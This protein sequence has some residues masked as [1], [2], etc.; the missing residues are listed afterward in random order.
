MSQDGMMS[1]EEERSTKAQETELTPEAD[2]EQAPSV[3]PVVAGAML[4]GPMAKAQRQALV[5]SVGQN[6]GNRQVQ[7][8][9]GT[10]RRKSAS[11]GPEG[12]PL[13]S[14]IA[15]RIQSARAT[16]QP[17]PGHIAEQMS[18][19]LGQDVSR[20]QVVTSPEINHDL[21]AKAATIGR[22][23]IVNSSSDLE[24]K[25]LMRHE[26]THAIQQGFSDAPPTSIGAADTEHEKAAEHAAVSGGSAQGV[27][28]EVE[29]GTLGLMREDSLV[30]RAG[31]EEEEEGQEVG[32][33]RDP[34]A[35][36]RAGEEDEE[37]GQEVGLMRDP[38][39]LQR[40]GEEDEEEGQEV[41]LM[42]E[43]NAVQRHPGEEE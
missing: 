40:A 34:N 12:G 1:Y 6:F 27:Q 26:L 23:V 14:D 28:R 19:D 11:S 38:N 2:L 20:A 41:G 35:I 30:Q 39:V 10:V 24:D 15:S 36:Q 31:E 3:P 4:K 21:G 7:R 16:A 32:L 13:E 17:L 9:L 22:T 25:G 29:D 8:M 43:N 42:R 37:E 5:Q 33:M 18:N